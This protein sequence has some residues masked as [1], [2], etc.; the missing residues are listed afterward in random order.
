MTIKKLEYELDPPEGQTL[1]HLIGPRLPNLL[2]IRYEMTSKAHDLA[3]LLF[4]PSI[5]LNSRTRYEL[6]SALTSEYD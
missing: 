2:A 3:S 4:R 5:E 6:R 1:T